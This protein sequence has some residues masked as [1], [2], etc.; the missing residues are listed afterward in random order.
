[1]PPLL[2]RERYE[3]TVILGV[4]FPPLLLV[5]LPFFELRVQQVATVAAALALLVVAGL[6]A[7]LFR[8]RNAA[9]SES[10]GQELWAI[11]LST[12][13]AI[14]SLLTGAVVAG[15]AYA[16]GMGLAYAIA[17]IIVVSTVFVAARRDGPPFPAQVN[18][19]A[20]AIAAALGAGICPLIAIA[21]GKSFFAS[22][23]VLLYLVSGVVATINIAKLKRRASEA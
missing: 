22:V 16:L 11:G 14:S 1:V 3:S 10:K 21:L 9:P 6:G 5:A 12:G 19:R 23:A 7:F 13:V 20:V 17:Y 4:V 2:A 8:Q 15:T 18:S